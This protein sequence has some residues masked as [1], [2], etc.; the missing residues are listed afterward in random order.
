MTNRD[1]AL[2]TIE[3]A[4]RFDFEALAE[5]GTD[6][7]EFDMSRSIGPA[8]GVYRGIDE[9]RAFF[10]Q[11]V[12][13]FES[14]IATPLEFYERGDWMAI[15]LEV[16]VRGRGSGVETTARGAR[17]YGF[18]DGK[19]ARYIQFQDMASAREYVDAQP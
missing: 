17:A 5:L 19:I 14:V 16:R 18:R 8:S 12:E 6:D 9:T 11:Y 13:V 3:A 4:N 7:V 15:D 10:E 1:V 2:R